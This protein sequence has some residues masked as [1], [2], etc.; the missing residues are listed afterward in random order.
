MLSCMDQ[1]DHRWKNKQF[2]PL[3]CRDVRPRGL[4]SASRPKNLCSA[5]WVWRP[6]CWRCGLLGW[7]CGPLCWK[8][9]PLCWTLVWPS[10]LEV[11][12]SVLASDVLSL[13]MQLQFY[14]FDLHYAS[15]FQRMMSPTGAPELG[16]P[17]NDYVIPSGRCGHGKTVWNCFIFNCLSCVCK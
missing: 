4:A 8:C 11:W 13:P 17:I 1:A 3:C 6:L 15:V 5:S 7:R 12:P 10:V 9:G 14:I 16:F 2:S